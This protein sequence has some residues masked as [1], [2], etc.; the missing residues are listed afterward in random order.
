M[1][2]CLLSWPTI[3]HNVYHVCVALWIFNY[4]F[5][6]VEWHFFND[7]AIGLHL[8]LHNMSCR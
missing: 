5:R 8:E 7:Q 2:Q 1:I 6:C 4:F 3:S